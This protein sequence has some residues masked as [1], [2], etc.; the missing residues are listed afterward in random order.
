MRIVY[1]GNEKDDK[2]VVLSAMPS[3]SA[4]RKVNT[5]ARKRIIQ[6]TAVVGPG[7]HSES[8]SYLNKGIG[9][10][11]KWLVRN[12][13]V[14]HQATEAIV[15]ENFHH[16]SAVLITPGSRVDMLLQKAYNARRSTVKK[17]QTDEQETTTE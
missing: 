2:V 5:A 7:K 17:G 6:E 1:D 12:E 8:Y 3:K 9:G 14:Y 4:W 11:Y 10:R 15:E 13:D 16:T